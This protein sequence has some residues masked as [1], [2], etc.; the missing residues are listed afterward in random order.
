M[1]NIESYSLSS[2]DTILEI[3]E[4]LKF[5]KNQGNLQIKYGLGLDL[6]QNQ[7]DWIG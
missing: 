3:K 5:K 6:A 2:Q 1:G 7:E 4:D